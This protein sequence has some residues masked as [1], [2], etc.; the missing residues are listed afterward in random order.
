MQHDFCRGLVGGRAVERH[1]PAGRRRLP[2]SPWREFPPPSSG[3]ASRLTALFVVLRQLNVDESEKLRAWIP[4]SSAVV[5][6]VAD[7]FRNCSAMCSAN[8]DA[9][10]LLSARAHGF[11]EICGHDRRLLRAAPHLGLPGRDPD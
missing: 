3:D 4:L 2:G 1:R 6:A 8:R 5:E 9:V 11:T 7:P 10:H